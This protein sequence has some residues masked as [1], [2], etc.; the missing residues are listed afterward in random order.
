MHYRTRKPIPPSITPTTTRYRIRKPPIA[1]NVVVPQAH[2]RYR[3]RRPAEAHVFARAPQPHYRIRRSTVSYLAPPRPK[4]RGRTPA[5]IPDPWSD[6]E[7]EEHPAAQRAVFDHPAG[8]TL[9]EIG[10]CMGITRERVRQIEH[11]ALAKLAESTGS[12]VSWLGQTTIAI[13]E[14]KKCGEAFVRGTGRQVF[15]DPCDALRKKKR[16]PSAYSLQMASFQNV[17]ASA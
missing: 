2:A 15:C 10:A 17:A 11:Q 13:P 1:V 9:E 4:R 3:V 14:C 7:W 12:D 16:R 8:M 6:L 5:D